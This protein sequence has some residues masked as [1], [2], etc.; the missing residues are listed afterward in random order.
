M[1]GPAQLGAVV[2][3]LLADPEEAKAMGERARKAAA[4][5]DV[6]LDRLWARIEGLLPP[7]PK[8]PAR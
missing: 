7:P 2:G 3:P 4:K 1:K 8:R 6:G 5:A